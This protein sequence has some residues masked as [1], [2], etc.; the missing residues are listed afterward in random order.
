MSRADIRAVSGLV[1]AL[2]ALKPLDVRRVSS[3]RPQG[4]SADDSAGS[5]EKREVAFAEISESMSACPSAG[6]SAGSVETLGSSTTMATQT[7]C[8]S[9]GDSAG[10][11]ETGWPGPPRNVRTIVS[12]L[13]PAL[14]AL[15]RLILDG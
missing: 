1:T 7:R 6:N 2:G 8:L 4:L 14:R 11:V 15:K 13:S 10:R 5:V 3:D 12:A 9:A